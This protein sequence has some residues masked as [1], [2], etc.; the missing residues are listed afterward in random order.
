M[1]KNNL[2]EGDNKL[3]L[4]ENIPSISSTELNF[5]GSGTI[6][7]GTIKS[8][9]SVRVDGI[10]KGKLLCKN[11]LTIGVNGQ[12]EGEVEAKK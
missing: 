3:K 12:I 5:L 8:D 11:T 1:N 2:T 6:V 10:I 9:S 7:E 4:K